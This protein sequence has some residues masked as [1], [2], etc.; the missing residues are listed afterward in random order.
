MSAKGKNRSQ[1]LDGPRQGETKKFILDWDEKEL[2][3]SER[4]DFLGLDYGKDYS[5][6][7]VFAPGHDRLALNLYSSAKSTDPE[8]YPMKKEGNFFHLRLPGD[9]SGSFYTYQVGDKEVTDP[10][11]ISSSVNSGK[12]A[13]IDLSKTD[14]PGFRESGYVQ[15]SCKD[16]IICELHIGDASFSESSGVRWRGRY[17]GLTQEGT[18]NNGQATGLDHLKELGVTHV[19]L[20]PVFDFISVNEERNAFGNDNNYNWGYDPELYNS[21]EGSYSTRPFNP[22]SR[23]QQ[24]KFLIQKLHKSGIGVVMDV[25]YNHVFKTRDSNLNILAPGYYF[26]KDSKGQ[27]SNGSGVGNELATEKPMV[28]RLVLD[29]LLYWQKEYKIDGF[30]FDLMALLD[31]ETVDL[32]VKKLREVN[33]SCLLYGEPWTG[34]QTSLVVDKMTLWGTQSKRGFALFNPFFRDAIRGD[35][36]GDKPGFI[37]GN[38]SCRR[39]VERGLLGSLGIGGIKDPIDSLNYFNVHDNLILEDKLQKTVSDPSKLDDMTRLAFGLLLTA[40]GPALFHLGNSFRRSKKG[41]KNSYR[42]PY[43]VNAVDWSLKADHQDLVKYVKDLI[44]FRKEEPCFCLARGEEVKERVQLIPSNDQNV[45][46]SLVQR[47]ADD[48]DSFLLCLYSNAWLTTY[49]DLKPVFRALAAYHMDLQKIF[50]KRGK[51]I[52]NRVRL[53]WSEGRKLAVDP[54]SMTIYS[55]KRR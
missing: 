43:S 52:N 47:Q 49:I 46:I 38:T 2:T 15:T 42:S 29:S 10:Y 40:Q 18:K 37:Q 4:Q 19:Q 44:A 21:P 39:Q 34:G 22:S 7:R 51:I 5:C 3:H 6:F 55:V 16:A 28:R 53:A 20:M 25:V 13:I 23:V 26:R 33:P 32:L 30:R 41:D 14:P 9:L 17:L 12:S 24:L 36:D 11:S 27:L 48:P 50:D 8:V 54:I 31:K 35:N 45:I 1:L